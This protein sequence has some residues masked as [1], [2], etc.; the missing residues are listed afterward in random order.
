MRGQ[1]RM[2]LDTRLP[3]SE[4]YRPATGPVGSLRPPLLLVV[5]NGYPKASL[6]FVTDI[7]P[8]QTGLTPIKTGVALQ[9]RLAPL[10]SKRPANATMAGLRRSKAASRQSYTPTCFYSGGYRKPPFRERVMWPHRLNQ[11]IDKLSAPI[12]LTAR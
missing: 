2:A 4:P 6:A 8:L 1:F 12:S 3:T 5:S 7:I 11:P 9:Q 10:G